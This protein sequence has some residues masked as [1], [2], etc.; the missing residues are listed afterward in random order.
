MAELDAKKTYIF[1]IHPHG[2]LPFGGVTSFFAADSGPFKSF[3]NLF[4][5]IEVRLLIASFC[6]MMPIYRDIIL[7]LGAVDAARFSADRVLE[8][9][10]SIAVVPGGGIYT[11]YTY[12][13]FF[14]T[15]RIF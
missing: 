14:S 11:I 5:G 8:S 15:L 9:G 1:C 6:F 13:C 12:F 7:S 2:L 10:M 3:Q 4:P